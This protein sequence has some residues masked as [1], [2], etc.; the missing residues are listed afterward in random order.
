M[1]DLIS[2]GDAAV[3]HFFEIS[4]AHVKLNKG[5]EELCLRFG[6]KLPVEKYHLSLGGNNPNNAVGAVRLGLQT[7]I[8]VNV[9][10]DLAGKFTLEKLKEE[11]V[12]TRYVVINKGMDSNV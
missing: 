5:V 8:Y 7:A 4:D 12:D 9:G 2:I 10:T 11:K 6:D 3:D 1:F